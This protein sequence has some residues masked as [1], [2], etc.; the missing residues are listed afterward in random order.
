MTKPNSTTLVPD[1]AR[2]EQ[3]QPP[4]SG[5]QLP[6]S[7]SQNGF[8]GSVHCASVGQSAAAPEHCAFDVH[9]EHPPGVLSTHVGWPVTFVMHAPCEFDHSCCTVNVPTV[10]C[11]PLQM[12]PISPPPPSEN[13]PTGESIVMP[14][15]MIRIGRSGSVVAS[16][17]S[18]ECTEPAFARIDAP[19]PQ[20]PAQP[21]CVRSGIT[22]NASVLPL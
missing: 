5:P 12:S 17:I 9:T 8:I 11:I 18:C 15:L 19:V 20:L 14:P 10:A 2:V 13:Q 3:P 16:I 21:A 6:L 1:G 22:P 7:V 4:E